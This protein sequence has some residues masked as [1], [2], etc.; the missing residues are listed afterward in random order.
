MARPTIRSAALAMALGTA[1][2]VLPVGAAHAVTGQAAVVSQDCASGGRIQETVVNNTSQPTTFTLNWPGAGT[3]TANVAANDSSH[4][5]FTKPSGTGYT[6]H[7]TT[8]QG[9]DDTVS[10]T[11]DC[12]GALHALVGMDCPRNADGSL[13]ASHRLRMTLDNRTAAAQTFTVAWPGRSGSPWTVTVPAMSGNA[14]LY[15]TVANGTPYSFTTTSGSWSHSESGT[16]DCG[17]A[18][19]TP[20]MNAQTLLT[21]STVI[22]GLNGPGGLYNGTAKSVR[23]PALAVTDSGTVIATMDAR[24]DGS[25]DLG[26][27]TNNIQI[28][29]SRSTDG[30]A[31]FTAPAIIAHAPTTGEGYGDSSLLVDRT[32][33]TVYCFFT[34]APKVGVGYYGSTAGDTSATS[35]ANTHI[36]YISSTDD[37]ATWSSA[38]DLNPQVREASWAGMFA[39]SGH[40]IQLASGRLVQPT[41]YHDSAGDHASNIYSDDH[42]ATWHAGTSAAVGFNENK[43]VQRSTGKVVQN[44]RSNSGG[45][46]WYATASD[47]G[48]ADVASGFG[49]AW[50]SGLLDPGCNGD[51]ISYLR[52]TDVDASGNPLLSSTAVLSN[53]A[54]SSRTDLTVRVS[55]DDGASWPHEALLA[56]G[57]AGYSTTAVLNNGTVGDLYEIGDTGGIVYTG[58]TLGWVENA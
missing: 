56:A 8:P 24:V 49:A 54:G 58:F 35:T 47:T 6:L 27:G 16:A 19:G 1:S 41:V 37:G 4:F 45:N 7:T 5:Y 17:T 21:T 3:W 13:P 2:A 25:A 51:E 26:G 43:A 46:R 11:M 32:T 39:S 36:R 50:N 12:T 20:G 53:A 34:Y 55:R 28:A 14:S 33:G 48:A 18:T 23:I 29:M 38:V 30:G 15:W 52:P 57:T 22:T 31:S 40:G 42:G 10:G 44:M 9:Y